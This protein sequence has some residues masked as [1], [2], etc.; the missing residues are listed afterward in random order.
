MSNLLKFETYETYIPHGTMK[1][2]KSHEPQSI[3]CLTYKHQK[4]DCIPEVYWV[5]KIVHYVTDLTTNTEI[6]SKIQYTETGSFLQLQANMIRVM[7]S[8]EK[9]SPLGF[10]YQKGKIE[11]LDIKNIN[12]SFTNTLCATIEAEIIDYISDD[13]PIEMKLHCDRETNEMEVL[14]IWEAQFERHQAIKDLCKKYE[15]N[16]KY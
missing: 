13:F 3:A 1:D 15:P 14:F 8:L 16:F 5:N 9:N 11:S 10:Y 6:T 7:Q 4:I 12:T 2:Y